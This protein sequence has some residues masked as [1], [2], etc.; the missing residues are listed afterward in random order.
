MP[1]FWTFGLAKVGF[2]CPQKRCGEACLQLTVSEEVLTQPRFGDGDGHL[3]VA[4]GQW[5]G[6]EFNYGTDLFSCS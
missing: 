3:H 6:K 1:R 5:L 2:D 4:E